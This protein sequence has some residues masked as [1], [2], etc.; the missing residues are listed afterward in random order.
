MSNN[1]VGSRSLKIVKSL[2]FDYSSSTKGI[3]NLDMYWLKQLACSIQIAD[4]SLYQKYFY[5]NFENSGR[6]YNFQW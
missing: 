6:P 4:Y 2:Q 1:I 5:N 3:I